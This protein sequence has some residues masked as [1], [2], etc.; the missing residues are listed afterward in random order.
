MTL[1]Q[2]D[3][4][5]SFLELCSRALKVHDIE[6]VP[7]IVDRIFRAAHEMK[8]HPDGSIFTRTAQK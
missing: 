7:E 5:E 2:S 6:T 3:T 4:P 1:M 8:G